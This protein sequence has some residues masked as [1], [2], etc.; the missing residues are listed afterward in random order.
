M[1]AVDPFKGM[2]YSEIIDSLSIEKRKA[3][4]DVIPPMRKVP[5]TGTAEWCASIGRYV[6]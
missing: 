6:V 4:V 1:N 5:G 3:Y 2:K